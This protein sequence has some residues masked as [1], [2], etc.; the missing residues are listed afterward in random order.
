MELPEAIT[1]YA[2][3][4]LKEITGAQKDIRA[5]LLTQQNQAIAEQQEQGQEQEQEQNQEE[6]E[7]NDK[8][9][10]GAEASAAMQGREAKANME[11]CKMEQLGLKDVRRSGFM[12]KQ[13]QWFSGWRLRYFE[14][15]NGF[16][17]YRLPS[18]YNS[19]SKA[20]E[21]ASKVTSHSKA[22]TRGSMPLDGAIVHMQGQRKDG[23]FFPFE[24]VSADGKTSWRLSCEDP[25]DTAE[26]IRIIVLCAQLHIRKKPGVISLTQQQ[27]QQHQQEQ[28]QDSSAS[29]GEVIAKAKTKIESDAA[30]RGPQA[31]D[32]IPC[33]ASIECESRG[34]DSALLA[35]ESKRRTLARQ[36]KV[37]TKSEVQEQVTF[38]Q[39]L[40]AAVLLFILLYSFLRFSCKATLLAMLL[41]LLR[42]KTNAHVVF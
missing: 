14:I 27:Q 4:M 16:L 38:V 36:Q 31:P 26:W 30:S 37:D 19:N 5:E 9:N 33:T 15:E 34:T 25:S 20:M 6:R 22:K 10:C 8:E 11:T 24:V 28:Q 13:R 42:I 1:E 2:S 32:K 18:N 23:L 41:F 17:K 3:L 40:V 29:V 7:S 39:I 12:Y 35:P 21:T